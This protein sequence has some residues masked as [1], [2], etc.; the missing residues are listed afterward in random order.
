[1]VAT[2]TTAHINPQC[3]DRGTQSLYR[4][5]L[6]ELKAAGMAAVWLPPLV[7]GQVQGMLHLTLE[8]LQLFES[9]PNS[10]G[11]QVTLRQ[12]TKL[13]SRDCIVLS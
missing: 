13:C 9:L 11:F 2:L 1:M 7:E 10:P 8:A 3:R 6:S 4:F 12:N 5:K